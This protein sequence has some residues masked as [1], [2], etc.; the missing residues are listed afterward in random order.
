[1]PKARTTFSGDRGLLAT[2]SS[3]GWLIRL[4]AWTPPG[5]EREIKIIAATPLP[6]EAA[7]ILIRLISDIRMVGVWEELD[8]RRRGTGEYLHP[9][10]PPA[11]APPRSPFQVQQSA[12]AE[13]L[14]F[15]FCSARDGRL[16]TTL[17]EN[18]RKQVELLEQAAMLRALA[19]NGGL[20]DIVEAGALMRAADRLE[21]EA[22]AARGADDPLTVV[23]HTAD[24]L[25]RGVQIDVA[26]FLL[27]RFGDRLDATAGTLTA[28]TLGLKKRSLSVSRSALRRPS[29]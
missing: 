28:V 16:A 17:G 9:A 22:A 19:A 20:A 12:M 5:V 14:H 7:A 15:A 13:T 18:A 27:D 29:P 10:R 8:R 4:P 24:P 21:A 26:S 1:M 23:R 6:D 11:H 25:A 2:S 3:D